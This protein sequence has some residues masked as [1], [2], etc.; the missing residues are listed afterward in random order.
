M[1][2]GVRARFKTIRSSLCAGAAL[3]FLFASTAFAQTV[4]E[5]PV[6]VPGQPTPALPLDVR[7]PPPPAPTLTPDDGLGDQGFYLE[8]DTLMRDDKAN[9]WTA[10]G[11]VE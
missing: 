9:T 8:A 7:K 10:T 6:H 4:N 11:K 3:A 2:E 1:G 5:L